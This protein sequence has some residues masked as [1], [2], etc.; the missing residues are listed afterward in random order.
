MEWITAVR[1]VLVILL[2]YM[3]LAKRYN[4]MLSNRQKRVTAVYPGIVKIPCM[5]TVTLKG[6][7]WYFAVKISLF[8]DKLPFGQH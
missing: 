6:S 4:I 1:I 5:I 3:Y 7:L 2:V 8:I